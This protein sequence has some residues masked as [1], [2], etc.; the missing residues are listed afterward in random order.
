MCS[1]Y[2][3]TDFV[4]LLQLIT[5]EPL[6]LKQSY[7]PHLKVLVCGINASSF[8]WCGSILK[9]C[10][11]YLKL[12]LLLHKTALVTFFFWPALHYRHCNQPVKGIVFNRKILI[13]NDARP[14]PADCN[15][16]NGAM[17]FLYIPDKMDFFW[18]IWTLSYSQDI[19][20]CFKGIQFSGL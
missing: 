11:T 18:Q 4:F 7:I 14:L 15:A 19:Q 13:E 3:N 9:T 5:F 20:S 2:S 1:F 10:Y 12:A 8:Q 17:E 6:Q 16:L